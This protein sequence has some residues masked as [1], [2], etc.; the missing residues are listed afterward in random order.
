MITSDRLN[1]ILSV[2]R[3]M[4]D[5]CIEHQYDMSYCEDMFTLGFLHDIGYEF[6]EH[7]DHNELGRNILHN[8]DYKYANEIKYHGVSN[9][10]YSSKELDILNWADM[11]IDGHGNYVSFDGRLLD[12]K[13]RRGESSD[14]YANSILIIN[15]L[16]SKGFN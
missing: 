1:H 11:H 13:N 8:Q 12:I 9:S 4:K 5:Y 6:G 15:E 10:P 2:A 3:L 14:A 16:I 7:A